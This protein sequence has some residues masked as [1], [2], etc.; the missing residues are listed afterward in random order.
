MVLESR[1][2][3]LCRNEYGGRCAGKYVAIFAQ[4]NLRLKTHLFFLD[5]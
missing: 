4:V 2:S 5:C 1:P 3:N